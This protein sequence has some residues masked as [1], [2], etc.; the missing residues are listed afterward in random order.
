MSAGRTVRT[1]GRR[2]SADPAGLFCVHVVVARAP[3]RL[4]PGHPSVL[5]LHDQSGMR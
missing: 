3:G 4:I 1:A 2:S 5:F